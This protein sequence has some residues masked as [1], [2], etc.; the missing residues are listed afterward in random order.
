MALIVPILRLFMLFL[1]IYDSLKVLKLPRPSPRNSGQPTVRALSQRKRNMKGCLAV[2]IV[3]CC[4]MT[5]E[6]M[7]EGIVSLFVPFYDEI[8]S[9]VLVFLILTRARGAEPIYL[10]VIRPVLKPYTSTIDAL[11][12][13]ARMFGDIVF[14]LLTYPFHLVSTWW[15]AA[16]AHREPVEEE[17]DRGLYAE[18]QQALHSVS[19][20]MPM[21]TGGRR[22]YSAPIRA[23]VYASSATAGEPNL[24]PYLR[25]PAE[26]MPEPRRVSVHEIWH[27]PRSAYQDE[28]DDPIPPPPVEVESEEARRAREQMD[29]WRQYPPFPSAYPPTPMLASSSRLPLPSAH[30]ISSRQFSSIPEG[31]EPAQQG[32]G[33]SLLSPH[34]LPN[35]GSAR[36][37]SDDDNILGIQNGS[38]SNTG[39][40]DAMD[41]EDDEDDFNVTLGTPGALTVQDTITAPRTR[42]RAKLA[43]ATPILVPLPTL[44]SRISSDTSSVSSESSAGSL[45]GRK[46][47]RELVVPVDDSVSRGRTVNISSHTTT[48]LESTE[49]ESSVAS[50]SSAASSDAEDA[51]AGADTTSASEPTSP[52]AKKRRVAAPRVQPRRTTRNTSHEPPAPV[53]PPLARRQAQRQPKSQAPDASSTRASS[54]LA[55][56]GPAAGTASRQRGATLEEEDRPS[57]APRGVRPSRRTAGGGVKR[58]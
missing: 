42:S 24:A 46:R 20:Q 57:V 8:K 2:W 12:D 45:V 29:E 36:D 30:D 33:Q 37:T 32:F 26:R 50:T 40:D 28:D 21:Q 14:L 51:D 39:P 48:M 5:Y 53:V 52:L 27:P 56:S 17:A 35:P 11:S 13:V 18:V 10:H 34:E 44:L 9:L 19:T 25:V 31:A 7:A 58:K 38:S 54:R 23:D 41:D 49:D 3:W 1:N 43:S 55:N 16:F 6:R 4:F 15:H 22:R 47:S